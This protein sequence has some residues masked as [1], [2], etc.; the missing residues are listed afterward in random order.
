[1]YE[2]EWMPGFSVT[3]SFFRKVFNTSFNIGFG[4]PLQDVCSDCLQL[5]E[6]LKI[7]RNEFEKQKLRTQYRIHKTREI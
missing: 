6:K 2:D 5:L 7:G 1:M 4:S 3:K